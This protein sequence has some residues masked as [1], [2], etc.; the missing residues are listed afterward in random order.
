MAKFI[1]EDKVYDT[2]KATLLCEN[3]KQWEEANIFFGKIYPHR[4]TKLYKTEKGNYFFVYERDYGVLSIS[5]CTE[6]EA[7]DW[8]KHKD[9]GKYVEMFGELEEA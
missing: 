2:E 7:K 5:I 9:Y 6:Q 3:V 4:P 8:L 1:V